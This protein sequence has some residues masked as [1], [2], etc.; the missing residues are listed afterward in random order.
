MCQS[1]LFFL[2]WWKFCFLASCLC[3]LVSQLR[4]TAFIWPCLWTLTLA[5]ISLGICLVKWFLWIRVEAWSNLSHSCWQPAW[6]AQNHTLTCIIHDHPSAA[7]TERC[8][9][10]R[11]STKVVQKLQKTNQTFSKA[12]SA[13]CWSHYIHPRQVKVSTGSGGTGTMVTL[14]IL[15]QTQVQEIRC[16]HPISSWSLQARE[17]QISSE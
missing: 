11:G 10:R 1:G 6:H 17:V 8:W 2:I 9:L 7:Q 3:S 12:S 15:L 13:L 4:V 5:R 16:S 14:T